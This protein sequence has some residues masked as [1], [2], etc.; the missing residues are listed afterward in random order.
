[1]KEGALFEFFHEEGAHHHLGGGFLV[2]RKLLQREIQR[3]GN[4]KGKQEK[5]KSKGLG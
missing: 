1:V 2:R 5:R 3:Q 4:F